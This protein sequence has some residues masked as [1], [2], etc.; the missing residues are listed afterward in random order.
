MITFFQYLFDFFQYILSGS[1]ILLSYIYD[2]RLN[3]FGTPIYLY[4]YLFYI[5]YV[6]IDHFGFESEG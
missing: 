3:I 2:E 4:L 6:L 1:N 5:I